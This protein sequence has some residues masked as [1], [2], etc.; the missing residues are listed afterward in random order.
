MTGPMLL[1]LVDRREDGVCAWSD[2][3]IIGVSG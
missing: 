2:L 3:R 1:T